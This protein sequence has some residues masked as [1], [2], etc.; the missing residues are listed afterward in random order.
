M[1]W[2]AGFSEVSPVVILETTLEC[3]YEHPVQL[4]PRVYSQKNG[5]CDRKSGYTGNL[6]LDLSL[7][8]AT[9]FSVTGPIC[10]FLLKELIDSSH[11]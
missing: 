5:S 9:R 3:P 10:I 6:S 2:H 7:S 1:C 8:P 11:R 4:F